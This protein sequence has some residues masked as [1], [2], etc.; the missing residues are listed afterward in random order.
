MSPYVVVPDSGSYIDHLKTKR[1]I[2]EQMCQCLRDYLCCDLELSIKSAEMMESQ[3]TNV[4][5]SL[6]LSPFDPE[7]T[8]MDRLIQAQSRVERIR[9]KIRSF[10]TAKASLPDGMEGWA[11]IMGTIYDFSGELEAA[12]NWLSIVQ[13]QVEA[14][15]AASDDRPAES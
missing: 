6:G 8:P 12:E 9:E 3:R 1:T 2:I 4:P 15:A 14:A 10:E 7:G 5:A 13:K 11:S